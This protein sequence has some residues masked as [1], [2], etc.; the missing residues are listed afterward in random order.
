MRIK[1]DI[2][3]KT[4]LR[5]QQKIY[6]YWVFLSI[7]KHSVL[8]TV[9]ADNT[10]CT[11]MLTAIPQITS[12]SMWQLFLLATMFSIMGMVKKYFARHL[13]C[14]YILDILSSFKSI[15]RIPSLYV[16]SEINLQFGSAHPPSSL[17]MKIKCSIHNYNDIRMVDLHH[18]KACINII[19]MFTEL[20]KTN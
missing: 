18:T 13:K 20:I 9:C 3:H 7:S 16:T 8:R 6:K 17:D 5:W 2:F 10:L 1:K 11:E 14:Y 15:V 4:L 12:I 19:F